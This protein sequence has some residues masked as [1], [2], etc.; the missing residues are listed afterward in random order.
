MLGLV[1]EETA[2]FNGKGTF[3]QLQQ[4]GEVLT[5]KNRRA[6]ALMLFY[7]AFDIRKALADRARQCRI[8]ARC[9]GKL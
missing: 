1:A 5:K 6:D 2:M 8:A 9:G 7:R 4:N 3:A